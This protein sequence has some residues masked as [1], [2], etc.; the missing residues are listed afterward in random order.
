ML[1]IPL[2]QLIA[3]IVVLIV[4]FSVHEFAHA[5]VADRFGDDTPRANGRLTL[6]P[7]AHLDPIG[8]LLLLVAG[9]GWAKHVPI[10]PYALG[11]RSSMAV[12]WVSLAGPM[13]NF[14]MAIIGAIPLRM[15]LVPFTGIS[16]TGLPSLFELLYYF[17]II[18]LTLML[19]NLIPIA[20]LDGEKIAVAV[21]PEK[22]GQAVSRFA[23][24]GPIVL[25]LVAFVLPY[26][27]I[28]VLGWIINPVMTNLLTLLIGA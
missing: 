12:M 9:F 24:Y 5:F 13:S 22:W 15:G 20:P 26:V 19:F 27:G 4:A 17:I 3:R 2:P 8:S 21:L 7:L 23:S 6:N 10:N 1:G 18:N 16:Q 25:L 28:N 11:R 14:L